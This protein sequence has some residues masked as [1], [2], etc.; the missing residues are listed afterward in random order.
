MAY[1]AD[2]KI[3]STQ[4]DYDMESL[5][6]MHAPSGNGLVVVFVFNVSIDPKEHVDNQVKSLLAEVIKN[7]KVTPNNKWGKYT[8]EGAVITGKVEGIYSGEIKIFAKTTDT[9]G[10]LIVSQMLN[11]DKETDERGIELIEHSFILKE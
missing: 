4:E 11:S 6:S 1:Y 10:F 8:G 2:W 7:G 5:F 9:K 3:D